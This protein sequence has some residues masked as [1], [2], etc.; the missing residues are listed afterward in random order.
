MSSS[1][2][3]CPKREA[4]RRPNTTKVLSKNIKIVPITI[5]IPRT[6]EIETPRKIIKKRRKKKVPK[7]PPDHIKVT[8]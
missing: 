1:E 6:I 3:S 5:I 4:P 8:D 7:L 2:D